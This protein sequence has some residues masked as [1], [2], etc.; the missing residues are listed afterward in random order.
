MFDWVVFYKELA[1]W[2]LPYR[3]RQKELCEILQNIGIESN[4]KD[5]DNEGA[6]PLEVMDPFTFFAFFQKF[7][8][9]DE[10]KKYLENFIKTVNFSMAAPLDYSG[11]P[12]AQPMALRYFQ[13]EK[14][15][16]K[17]DIDLLWD[18]AEQAV[19]GRLKEDT[20]KK[21][22]SFSGIQIAKLTQGLFW[23]NPDVFYPIDKHKQYLVENGI[24][25][26]I[27]N[28]KDYERVLSDI[29]ENLNK[30]FYEI[31]HDAWMWTNKQKGP[32]YWVFQGNPNVFDFVEAFKNNLI[33]DWTVSTF[34]DRI[35]TGD[36]VIIWLSGK[37]AGC[38]ALAEITTEPRELKN[39][40]DSHLWK[41][42]NKNK[43]ASGIKIS[44]NL[45]NKPILKEQIL[46][47]PKLKDLKVGIQGTNFTATEEEFNIILSMVETMNNPR[48]WLYAPGRN[49]LKWQEFYDEG[50]M[51]LGWDELGDLKKYKNSQEIVKVLQDFENPKSNKANDTK[52]NLDFR[53]GMKVGDV[54]IVKSGSKQLLGYGIVDSDYFYNDKRKDYFSCRKVKW[55]TNGL[56]EAG[57][58]LVQKTLT[59]ITVYTSKDL[60]DLKY[61]QKLLNIMKP[62]TQTLS[63]QLNQILFGPPGTG[64]TY[65]TINKAVKIANPDFNLNQS[66]EAVKKEYDRLLNDGQIVFTTFHQSM[67]YEDF[68][69]GIKPIEPKKDGQPLIYKVV[70]GIL[71]EICERIKSTEKITLNKN[72][73]TRI[74]NNFNDLFSAFIERLKEITSDLEENESHYFPSRRSRVKLLKVDNESILTIGESANSTETITKNKLERIY[75]KFK[76]HDDITDIVKQLREVGTDIGWVTNYYAVFKALKEFE[77]SIMSSK[78][79]NLLISKKQNYIIIID[80]IN[81]GN[82][83]QIFGELITLIEEDKRI[84][85]KEALEVVLPYSKDKFGV[86][87]NLYIIG[88]M[89]TADRSVE[90]LDAALRRRFDFVEMQPEPELIA[91]KGEL[92]ETHAVLDGL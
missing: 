86:P 24:I 35:Q 83:S 78:N 11:I 56:W 25:V 75:N 64:K 85:E 29:K 88:T 52:A 8:H 58:M 45:I 17:D 34:K 19:K 84:G 60:P 80:E 43:I 66:R 63:F 44:H 27:T 36:K 31:S 81:R 76:S 77:A 51:A 3:H 47:N 26:E 72:I 10:R 9:T 69:E 71:K 7:R 33:E 41:T 90:A 49:A 2:L 39:S 73:S 37:N 5:E 92:Q 18:L 1:K 20:F 23:L 65:N 22:L 48:Y 28:L 59:D 21:V 62:N 6:K 4:L 32:N 12:S 91:L 54:V 42:E 16:K 79:E 74:F 57:H 89:N 70:P 15:R 87:P 55:V 61:Y 50:I 13:I 14:K 82:I 30:P 67:C 53:D 46:R 38:Y 68:V 40:K